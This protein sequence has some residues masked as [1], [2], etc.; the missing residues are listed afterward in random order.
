MRTAFNILLSLA[1]ASVVGVAVSRLYNPGRPDVWMD[2]FD[3]WFWTC[4]ASTG[5]TLV[6]ALVLLFRLNR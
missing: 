5:T 3:R 2:G 6:V 4:V 1:L